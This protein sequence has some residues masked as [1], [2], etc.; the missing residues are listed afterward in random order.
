ME[1]TGETCKQ[2]EESLDAFHDGELPASE[3]TLVEEHLK[4]CSDCL[5]KVAQIERLVQNLKAIPSL[6]ASANL[7]SK[8]DQVVDR[9][10]KVVTLKP[11]IWMPVAAAAAVLAIAF[12]LRSGMPGTTSDAPTVARSPQ[13]QAPRRSDAAT[14]LASRPTTTQSTTPSTNNNQ[15]QQPAV[16]PNNIATA[17]TVVRAKPVAP[18]P[19]TNQIAAREPI[20]TTSYEIDN[21][22][23]AELPTTS[24]SFTDAVGF[25][26]DEDGLYDIKM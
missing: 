8:L 20:T 4:D 19:A 21:E 1:S 24:D 17:S 26:T 5:K 25:A 9:P 3:Q 10:N 12:G 13:M 16:R 23:I 11:R 15:Q 22:Q 2:I 7:S 6:Q 18:V 14:N